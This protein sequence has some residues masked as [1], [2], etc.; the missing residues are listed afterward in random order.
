MKRLFLMIFCALCTFTVSAQTIGDAFYIYRNDGQ[1]N[2]FFREEVDSL[3]YSCYDVD[4]LLHEDIVT[5]VVFTEDSIYRIP[6]AAIDSVSFVQ[7]ETEYKLNVMRMNEDWLPYVS[8]IGDN[9]I[10]FRANTPA[11]Y[12]PVVGQVIVTETFEEPFT[13]GFS[14]RVTN[15]VTN[16]DGIVCSVEEVGLSDIYDHIV[17]VGVSSSAG[18]SNVKRYVPRRIWGMNTDKGVRFPLPHL[19]ASIG[20]FSVSCDPS[21]VMK[22]IVCV[23]ERNLKDYVSI[24]VYTILDGSASM[25][26]KRESE[27][28][29]EPNWKFSVPIKTSIP[30]LYG[31]V[32]VGG[33]FRASGKVDLSAT[34]S[35]VI[36]GYS[37][38]IKAEG[39]P[40]LR[41]N[42]WSAQMGDLDAEISLDGVVSGGVAVQLQFGIIHEK[43]ASADITAYV[44]PQIS[45]HFSLSAEG[46]VDRT[47]YSALKKSEVKLDF[48]AEIVPG[49]RFWGGEHQEAPVS[50][51]LGYN[52]NHWYIV[53]EFSN[54]EYKGQG[55]SGLL[56]GDINRN[57]LPKVSL[58]WIL[59]DKEDEIYMKDYFNQKYR[60]IEDWNNTG[61]DYQLSNLPSGSKYKAYPL[62]K[63]FGV[64]MRGDEYV[65]IDTDFPVVLSDFK[66]TKSQ[67]KQNGFSNDGIQYDYRFDAS[68]T[69][70]LDVDDPSQI[71]DWGYAYL[72]PNG[73]EALI[74]L[75]QFGTKY[76][77]TRYAYFRN[78]AHSTCTLYGYVK[79]VGSDEIIYGE[80]HDYPFDYKGLT[81]CPDNNHPHWID[82]GLPSGTQ[83]RC[84][85]EGAS[86]PEAYGGY[87][88]FG[89]VGSAP[90][91]DQIEE[92]LNYCTSVWT[93]LNG[94]NGR[95]FTGPN[96]GTIFL[97][98][99]GE[100]WEGEFYY[101]G[102][103]G[104]SWSSTPYDSGNAY[105]LGFNSIGA[106]RCI[107][108]TR[109]YE[110]SVRPVR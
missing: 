22:Y 56:K 102:S 69:V 33:F 11:E 14:G 83:W 36:N 57:L 45:A 51:N 108:W 70:T 79:Y 9:Y 77:D 15:V 18:E 62:V 71:A 100:R 37:S 68:V 41:E 87:Y 107:Y 106:Y 89:Q 75:R 55:S 35:F 63:L 61:L 52:I 40:S 10:T 105:A 95:K 43:I 20:P 13:L 23:G 91:L 58:G 60:K 42:K 25:E 86:S 73:R 3:V 4:S 88:S 12:L 53:P 44:G 98:A 90:T 76:T 66:V 74:S 48:G 72:D 99:A 21:V 29:P 67:Y 24:Q 47:L 26:V 17:S 93:T 34:Q 39:Q 103:L 64:E 94:V 28:H 80:P 110:L 32:R 50:L 101:V 6:L 104:G 38:F 65:D 31:R 84:C 7:P 59:Y 5:Q 85:N 16:T 49:Y 1:F 2:A 8:A 81:L 82:L 54:L 27:Y 97:P 19:D 109:V 46:L 78:A 30:G 92:L 96:G